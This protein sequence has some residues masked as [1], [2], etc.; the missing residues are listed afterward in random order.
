M[1]ISKKALTL[2][3]AIALASGVAL[4]GDG[5]VYLNPAVGYQNF[6]GDRDLDDSSLLSLG[7]GYRYNEN[8]AMEFR[9]LDS[10]PDN[11]SS[12][13]DVDLAQ[14]NWSA[15]YFLGKNGNFDPFLAFG[16]GHADFDANGNGRGGK[17]TQVNGGFGFNYEF[18][19]RWS[20]RTEARALLSDSRDIDTMVL[21]G[22][23]YAFGDLSKPVA[24]SDGDGVVDGADQCPTTP[25]G[26]AVDSVG[27]ALDGDNDGV[28]DYK[29]Q[30]LNTPA[31]REVDAKGCKLVLKRAVEI[32]LQVNFAN[33]S[34]DVTDQYNSDIAEVA[35]FLKR[36]AGVNADIEG[37]TDSNG[38]EA[39]NQS[40]SQRRAEAVKAIL[41]KQY[42]IDAGRLQ[43]V[44]YG[45]SKPIADN[46]TAEGRLANRRV[47]AVMKAEVEE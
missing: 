21:A 34:A 43:A 45:E 6:D 22:I 18:A 47:V 38:A 8:W 10:E 26:V 2:L 46:G 42:G 37:H 5:Y 3:P 32:A 12:S 1:K 9:I 30:C 31:G 40:L 25:A 11:E 41:V 27:C 33:N 7:L 44:G 15:L 24:D 14:Y 39:Y 4:A 36:Y 29:D 28:P 23:S 20:L 35:D 16:L 19:N 17:D 13:S